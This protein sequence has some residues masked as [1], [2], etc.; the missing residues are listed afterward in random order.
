[1]QHLYP[2][3]LLL[4]KGSGGISLELLSCRTVIDVAPIVNCD[5][6]LVQEGQQTRIIWQLA[7]QSASV[8]A[9]AWRGMTLNPEVLNPK[10]QTLNPSHCQ[11]L[12]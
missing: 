1:M 9:H 4:P 8:A 6:T 12:F 3:Y 10:P 2:L 7:V 5:R 11:G